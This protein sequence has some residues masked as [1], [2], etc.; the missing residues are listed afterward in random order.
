M[1]WNDG[2]QELDSDFEQWFR[3]MVGGAELGTASHRAL[4]VLAASPGFSARATAAQVAGRAG[5]NPA[6]VVRVAKAMGF[7]GWAE[8]QLE[9]R[10]RYLSFLEA[11]KLLELHGNS[12]HSPTQ[13]AMLADEASLKLLNRTLNEDTLVCMAE[14]LARSPRIGL[15]GSGSHVGPLMQF[16]HVGSR[17]GMATVLIGMDG[18]STNAIMAQFRR[19][20]ALLVL[21][22]WRTPRELEAITKLAA[23][24]QMSILLISDAG[25]TAIGELATHSVICPA[26]GS[27]HF[28]S[29]VA[30]NSVIHCLLSVITTLRGEDG[31]DEIRHHEAVYQELER[32]R[33]GRT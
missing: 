30:A 22:L 33:G 17:L 31:L 11:H 25:R 23:S 6:T 24:M 20:D 19:G 26:E 12:G 13:Q 2:S 7:A 32:I 5:V 3:Q 14:I 28:P 21:N 18:R 8:L 15:L 10:A 4:R 27:S 29:L 1:Q 16:S 9:I